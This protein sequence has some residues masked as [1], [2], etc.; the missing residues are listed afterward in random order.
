MSA[1]APRAAISPS[2]NPTRSAAALLVL[3]VMS[4]ACTPLERLAIR[5]GFG[6]PEVQAAE[7]HDR[8]GRELDH[9]RFSEL[10]FDVVDDAGYVDYSALKRDPSR[11]EAYLEELAEVPYASLSRDGK[12]AAL[13]NAYNAFTL[14][15]I[16]EHYPLES[17]KDIPEADRWE[18]VRW[19]VGGQMMSLNQ[20]EH[21]KLRT[22][23]VEPRIHFAINCASVS[24]PPLAQ[25]AYEDERLEM[26][27]T[28]AARR[29]HDPAS[30]WF[31]IDLQGLG[32][33]PAKVTRI[34][35]WYESDFPDLEQAI[36]RY[37][38]PARPAFEADRLLDVEYLPYDWSL[39][40]Q[41]SRPDRPF[42]E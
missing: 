22:E 9:S 6:P 14:K 33:V 2:A 41:R 35:L 34:Y 17:I 11:L 24:C 39:N 30:R 7:V 18:A 19:N 23:F 29:V 36:G 31:H 16:V 4:S 12:M 20:I 5:L 13:I 25:T 26:D 15:L 8:E 42:T 27:L 1:P 40:D 10:L 32:A 38:P 37:Y 3:A 21:E 28:R